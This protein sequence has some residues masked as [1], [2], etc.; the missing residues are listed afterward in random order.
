MTS[1]TERPLSPGPIANDEANDIDFADMG[2]PSS[3]ITLAELLKSQ[4]YHTAHIG[5][6]HLGQSNG[7]AAHKQGFD[8]SLLMA[9]GLYGRIDDEN[10]VQ[11][12]QDFDPL[13][14]SSGV[15]CVS[16]QASMVV[17]HLSRPTI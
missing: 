4:G 2:M 7:M 12:R 9:S 8:E 3:E 5:K 13:T 10:V 6:W 15:R 17:Q 14:A 16:R 11:A 1:A